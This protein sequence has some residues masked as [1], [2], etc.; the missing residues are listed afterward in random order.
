MIHPLENEWMLGPVRDRFPASTVEIFLEPATARLSR[1]QL[2]LFRWKRR[3]PVFNG[4]LELS[5]GTLGPF[6]VNCDGLPFIVPIVKDTPSSVQDRILKGLAK[7]TFQPQQ[8]VIVPPDPLVAVPFL[9]EVEKLI[10]GRVITTA[11]IGARDGGSYLKVDIDPVPCFDADIALENIGVLFPSLTA[12]PN[13][14]VSSPV[15]NI[16]HTNL[17]SI[18]LDGVYPQIRVDDPLIVQHGT[19]LRAARVR[20]VDIQPVIVSSRTDPPAT[21]P[22]TVIQI[23]LQLPAIGAGVRGIVIHFNMVDG[24]KITRIA[25]THLDSTDFTPPGVP[26]E[27]LVEPIPESVA[28]PSELLLLD[29]MDN[30]VL[31]G[32][33]V[34]INEDGKGKVQLAP[35]TPAFQSALRTPVTIFGN[36][37]RATRGESVFNEVLGSGVSQAFQSFTLGNKPLTYLNHPSA[38]NGRRSTLEVRVNGIKWKEVPSFFGIGPQDEVYI[39]RQ[40]DEQET[41]ITFGDGKTGARLPTGVDNVTATYRFGAGAASHRPGR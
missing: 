11:R 41:I 20:S 25:K 15:D 8:V 30:G 23:E 13:P 32:G 31:A 22:A 19:D 36:L 21:L 24:G 28:K 34:N 4:V 7:L 5:P 33:A 27:G 1:D 12:T 39:V 35:D 26:T 37:V 6:S 38:P 3:L 18:V 10:P 40:N 16:E 2:V 29:A 14:F 9:A 17:T